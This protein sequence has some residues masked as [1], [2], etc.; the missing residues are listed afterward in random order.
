MDIKNQLKEFIVAEFGED[1][2]LQA[3]APD[4][5]LIRQGIVD[6]MGVLQVVNFIEQTYGAQVAD[7][8][9]TVENFRTINAIANL[10]SQK[11]QV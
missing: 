8:E 1:K 9:I 5:D 7:E 6:S 10:V 2:E 11:T 4:D 3:L